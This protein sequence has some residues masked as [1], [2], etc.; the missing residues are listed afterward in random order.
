[1]IPAFC[2]S[3]RVFACSCV[4]LRVLTCKLKGSKLARKNAQKKV[5]AAQQDDLWL[6]QLPPATS[7]R[8]LQPHIMLTHTWLTAETDNESDSGGEAGGSTPAK[9]GPIRWLTAGTPPSS[10]HS[11]SALLG[12][13]PPRGVLPP[14]GNRAPRSLGA[15]LN[16]TAASEEEVLSQL[17]GIMHADELQSPPNDDSELVRVDDSGFEVELDEQDTD[18]EGD[19]DD[20]NGSELSP[21]QA[22]A[23]SSSSTALVVAKTPTKTPTK[24]AEQRSSHIAD[25]QQTGLSRKAC[26]CKLALAKGHQSC[27]DVFSKAQLSEF[28]CEGHGSLQSPRSKGQVLQELHKMIWALKVELPDGPD[29]LGHKYKVP[30]WTLRGQTVCR[31]A[32]TSAY[33]Y[34]HH[35]VRLRLALVLQGVGPAAVEGRRLAEKAMVQMKRVSA[36]KKDWATQWWV[37]HLQLHDFLPNECAIQVRGAHW[38]TVYDKQFMPMAT[39]V[40]MDCCRATWMKARPAALR[41]LAK[42]YYPDRPET[43]LKLKR[44]ANHS[45][46]AECNTCS[47][48]KK[49]CGTYSPN[50]NPDLLQ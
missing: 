15:S 40:R 6:L 19:E 18:D 37:L 49:Q 21:G 1:M 11:P 17:Q 39:Q 47:T 28:Y 32:W 46:F 20:G 10:N 29:A 9:P 50:Q 14:Q 33:N 25:L 22:A 42:K 31:T 13:E 35:G 12:L 41:L 4:F 30:A 8:P 26:G 23:A 16:N 38:K 43:A 36:G 3:L 24:L 44:S 2:A 34:T 27:L 5:K 7:A 45:R 48:L